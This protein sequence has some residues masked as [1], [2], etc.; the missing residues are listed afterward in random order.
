MRCASVI[1]MLLSFGALSSAAP[2]QP[3]APEAPGSKRPYCEEKPND[4]ACI[5]LKQSN[6]GSSSGEGGITLAPGSGSGGGIT[7]GSGAGTGG[8]IKDFRLP[9]MEQMQVPKYG[10]GGKIGLPAKTN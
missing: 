6:G 4:I 10:T 7:I 3:T 2:A 9:G 8:G 5:Y 1:C